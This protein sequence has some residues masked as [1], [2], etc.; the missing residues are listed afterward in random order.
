MQHGQRIKDISYADD[1]VLIGASP[2]QLQRMMCRLNKESK[3]N[4]MS[5]NIKKTKVMLIEKI[6][7]SKILCIEI[8]G[9]LL[10]QVDVY[11]YLGVMIR[12][13]GRDVTEIACHIAYACSDFYN[14]EQVLQNKKLGFQTQ[15]R[16]V[17]CYVWSSLRYSSEAWI[18]SRKVKAKITSFEM[19]CYRQMQRIAWTDRVRNMK[20]CWQG[21]E[22]RGKCCSI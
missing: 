20:R 10:E 18:L 6:A 16:I 21:V 13:E 4:D 14:L 7:S 1:K 12:S 11:K 17:R 2:Q 22:F 9:Q 19:R 5:I 15:L 8:D 3:K